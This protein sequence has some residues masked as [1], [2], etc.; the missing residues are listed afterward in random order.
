MKSPALLL[1][2]FALAPAPALLAQATG[3][4]TGR[5]LNAATGAYLAGASITLEGAATGDVS[6]DGGSFRVNDLP[7]GA[8]TLVVTYPGLD[9]ARVPVTVVAG[10]TRDVL[11]EL[12]SKIYQ[13]DA[14]KVSELREGEAAAIA[15]QRHAENL[16][17]V[18]ATDTFGAVADTNVGNVLL[19]LP[20]IS[21]QRDEGEVH[22]VS[23][24][25]IDPQFNSVMVDG[26]RLSGATT[27]S[28]GLS[29]AFEVDKVSTNSIESIEVIKAQLPEMDADAIGGTINLKTKSGFDRKGR[30]LRWAAGANIYQRRAVYEPSGSVAYSDVLGRERRLGLA[31]N[32]SYNRT[33]GPRSAFRAGYQNPS[34]TGPTIMND[35][36]T[37]E[38]E[39]TLTRI[40]TGLKFDYKLT[41]SASVFFNALYNNYLDAMTQHK[42]RMRR[43]TATF[44]SEAVSQL[45]GASTEYEMESRYRTVKTFRFQAGGKLAWRDWTLDGDAAWSPSDGFEKREDATVRIN[46]TAWRVDK[47][48]RLHYPAFTQTAGPDVRNFDNGFVDGMNRKDFHQQDE[49]Y[50][51]QL[52]AKRTFATAWPTS[53]KGGLRWREQTKRQNRFQPNYVYVGPDGVA[54]TNSA[55]GRNDDNLNR[56][57]GTDGHYYLPLD[58]RYAIVPAW[59]DLGAIHRELRANPALFRENV[60]TSIR[61]ALVNNGSVRE[62]VLASYAQG[63]VDIGRLNVLAGVRREATTATAKGPVTDTRFADTAAEAA[64]RYGGVVK[65]SRDYENYFPSVHARYRIGSD[66]LAR[67]SWSTGIGRAPYG[68]LIPVTTVNE[69]AGTIAR[70]NPGL[71]P[72]FSRNYDVSLEHYFARGVGLVSI[73]AFQKNL[74]N[75]IFPATEIIGNGADNGFDGLYGGYTLTTR[76]NGGWARVRGLELNYQQS[77]TFLPGWLGGLG[78]FANATRLLTRG[79]YDGTT[80][81]TTIAGFTPRIANA[82]L[83]WSRRGTTLRVN[84]N[85]TGEAARGF[86]ANPANITYNE[87]RNPVDVSVK[88]RATRSLDVF[89]D[90]SNIFNEKNLT[91]Q[92]RGDRPT[93]SQIYGVRMAAG[94]SGAF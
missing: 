75:F 7:P 41:P 61:N 5:V 53:L 19:R 2:I 87:P 43:G 86:N 63:T 36:Q 55:T 37:S 15:R 31:F 3:S 11:V 67:A 66:T 58:G 93:D 84:W 68:Q 88:V 76:V 23:I 72:Q 34:F 85:H 64:R 38:D 29:R 90:A 81:R 79:T 46:N 40:G 44:V 57:N 80:I 13:L 6:A 27:R 16:K 65:V 8:R 62:E 1:C 25:G 33:Y 77:L 14:F 9:A 17:Q 35:F 26:T 52:N 20:G 89:L 70:N 30:D 22:L 73:G 51:A 48:G 47:T 24:R 71:N 12:S 28:D 83:S 4:V 54:G 91:F 45:T 18:I 69:N 78:V 49:I 82:G 59:P 39:I 56:F 60:A 74:R 50:A 10:A 32:L 42:M 92:G 94:V 21:A